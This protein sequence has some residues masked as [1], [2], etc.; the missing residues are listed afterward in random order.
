MISGILFQL[1]SLAVF[2]F[3]FEL[4]LFRGRK[5]L[6]TDKYLVIIAA[7]TMLSVTC[8]IIRGIY[9]SIELLQG[10]SGYLITNERFALALDG[11]MIIVAVVV[12]NVFNPGFL[13]KKVSV[14]EQTG[15]EEKREAQS[16]SE[17][18]MG[19]AA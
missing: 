2:T 9:R 12:F 16:D 19:N 11:G 18:G 10:W 7:A 15:R 17:M 13:F 8:V 4:V 5:V 6:F 1:A 3:F 14:G